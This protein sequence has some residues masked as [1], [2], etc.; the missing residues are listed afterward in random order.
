M[1]LGFLGGFA[2]PSQTRSQTTTQLLLGIRTWWRGIHRNKVF[3]NHLINTE[4]NLF[5]YNI[6]LSVKCKLV[7]FLFTSSRKLKVC[8]FLVQWSCHPENSA[9]FAHNI[10]ISQKQ[11]INQTKTQCHVLLSNWRQ[12]AKF[13]TPFTF[14][15]SPASVLTN[16]TWATF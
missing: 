15:P 10:I 2:V 11:G 1:L 9:L 4:K 6:L 7:V 14:N 5:T 8:L 3:K 12:H 13:H 16:W